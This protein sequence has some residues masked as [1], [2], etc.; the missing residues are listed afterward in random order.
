[1]KTNAQ[2][3]PILGDDKPPNHAG[4]NT[5]NRHLSPL[6]AA[7][8]AVSGSDGFQGP[9]VDLDTYLA[10]IDAGRSHMEALTIAKTIF[11]G[12]AA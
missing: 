4:G 10:A 3:T 9:G 6:D 5:S 8:A 1:M 2:H 7:L 12:C 11:G